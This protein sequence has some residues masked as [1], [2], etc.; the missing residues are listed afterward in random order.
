MKAD[1]E[2]EAVV[3]NV[4]KQW[5][6]A[7]ARRDIKGVLAFAAPDPG[8]VV[9]G[10]GGDEK[11]IGPAELKTV[12]E[13]AFAQSEDASVQIGWYSVS[14]A[15]S[16]AWVAADVIFQVTTKGQEIRLTLRETAVLERRGDRWLIVQ[17]HDSLP[18]AGQKE[19]EAW[20]REFK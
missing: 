5:F 13:R 14:T 16:V 18:A 8:L 3:M 7:F 20:P 11:C 12:A 6:E 1:P 19:G 2:T 17:S 9:I 4:V 10:T 15:G